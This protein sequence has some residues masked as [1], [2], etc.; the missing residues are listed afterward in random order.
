[1]YAHVWLNTY[2]IRYTFFISEE[3]RDG[4]RALSVRDGI[5]ESEAIRRAIAG[6]LEGRNIRVSQ[7]KKERPKK[8]R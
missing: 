3:L 1:M 7:P 6:F 8:R 2:M 5:G 4:L